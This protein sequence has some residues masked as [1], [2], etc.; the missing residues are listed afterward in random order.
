MAN[1][2]SKI[3]QILFGSIFLLFLPKVQIQKANSSCKME[4]HLRIAKKAR[5]AMDRV[6]AKTF[7]IPP[8]S[9]DINPIENVFHQDKR[10]LGSD[11]IEQNIEHETFDEFSRKID[12]TFESM[13]KRIGMI[14]KCNE[15]RTK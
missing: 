6:G 13:N 11:A 4:T 9:P 12:R 5:D 14:I 1:F 15:K 2:M 8:R 3:L 10:K 7:I